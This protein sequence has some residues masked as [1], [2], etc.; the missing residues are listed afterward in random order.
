[1][2]KD[3]DNTWVPMKADALKERVRTASDLVIKLKELHLADS[4]SKLE[5]LKRVLE[6]I[7]NRK[8]D[9]R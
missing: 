5:N 9:P 7:A 8:A 4:R 3:K 2:K 6:A 1:M